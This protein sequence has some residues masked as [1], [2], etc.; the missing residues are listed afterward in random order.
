MESQLSVGATE[1]CKNN[2]KENGTQ[3][4]NKFKSFNALEKIHH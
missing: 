1:D 4:Q 3:R 2:Q